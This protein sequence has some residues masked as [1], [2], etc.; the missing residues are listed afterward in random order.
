MALALFLSVYGYSFSLA[1]FCNSRL[2]YSIQT[3]YNISSFLSKLRMRNNS[4]H[5]TMGERA[6]IAFFHFTDV[7]ISGGLLW[8]FISTIGEWQAGIYLGVFIMFAILRGASL[9]EDI[10]TKREIRRA[11]KIENDQLEWE[12]KQKRINLPKN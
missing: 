11:K 4:I 12:Y 2:F 9:I 7:L 5:Y 10:S 3:E 8:G 1:V 6:V